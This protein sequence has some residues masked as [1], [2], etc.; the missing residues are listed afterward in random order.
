MKRKRL[1]VWTV[2]MSHRRLWWVLRD[3][4]GE[5]LYHD[6]VKRELLRV[7]VHVVSSFCGLRPVSVRI[8][9]KNGRI[10]EERTFPRSADPRKSRG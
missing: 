6:R 10:Q 2:R 9:G 8:Y 5:Y 3:E 4:E 1:L 7:L